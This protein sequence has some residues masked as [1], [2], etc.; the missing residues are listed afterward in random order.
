MTMPSDLAPLFSSPPPGS[1]QDVRYRQGTIITFDPVTLSNTVNVGGSVLTDLP[2]LGVG[3]ITLLVPGAVVGLASIGLPGGG[4]TLAILGRFVRPNTADATN[5]VSLLSVRT[6]A[7]FDTNNVSTTSATYVDLGGP[8]V[9]GVVGPTGRVLVFVG[10]LITG[11]SQVSGATIAD[12]ARISVQMTGANVVAA[13][14]QWAYSKAYTLTPNTLTANITGRDV[15]AH[16]FE[17]L[18]PGYTT[19]TAVYDSAGTG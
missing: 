8:F 5:A 6:Q 7:A 9:S 12:V 15:A 18:T 1:A 17:N 10:G 14:D 19:F 2:V 16:L 11:N 4:Q 3:E 13:T